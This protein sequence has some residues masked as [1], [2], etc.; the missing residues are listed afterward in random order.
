MREQ[1]VI[2]VLLL[3]KMETIRKIQDMKKAEEQS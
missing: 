3:V 1:G 2:T